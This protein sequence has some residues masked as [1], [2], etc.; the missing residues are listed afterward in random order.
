MTQTFK[1]SQ[2]QCIA[3]DA[4]RIRIQIQ[5]GKYDNYVQYSSTYEQNTILNG[6]DGIY[7]TYWL[8]R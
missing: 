5:K 3:N 7:G 2:L 6:Q 4:D 8:G 1:K